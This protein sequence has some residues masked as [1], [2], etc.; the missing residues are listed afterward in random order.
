MTLDLVRSAKNFLRPLKNRL[1]RSR[2]LATALRR[3]LDPVWYRGKYLTHDYS[4]EPLEHYLSQGIRLGYSPNRW[5]DERFYLA[6][7]PDVAKVCNEG[8]ILCGFQHYLENGRREK[9]LT[10]HELQKC[11]EARMPGVTRPLLLDKVDDLA[12]R[13]RPI[14]AVK[15]ARASSTVWVL[16]PTLNPDITFG[17]Y[18][19]AIELIKTLVGRGYPVAIICCSEQ[20]NIE[21]FQHCMG[22]NSFGSTV[23]NVNLLNRFDLSG[24]V[25]VGINDRFIAYSCWE[26]H[27]AHGLA[28]L[29]NEP[30]FAL[31]AQEY[32]P[33]F[34]EHG[35]EHA[36]LNAAYDLPHLPIFNSD[37]LR[38]FFEQAKLGIFGKQQSKGCSEYIVI[39]HTHARVKAPTREGLARNGRSRRLVMYTRPEPHA[40][41]NLFPL[42][43]LGLSRAIERGVLVGSWEML[44]IGALS[45]GHRVQLPRGYELFL[46]PKMPIE[47]YALFIAG[48]DL[49]I[50]LMYA[51]HPGLVS[52]ELAEAGAR[53]VTNTFSIRSSE[54]LRGISENLVPCDPTIEGIAEGIER[55]VSGLDDTESRLRGANI[56]GPRS[57]DE[58]FDD[59]FFAKL[60]GFFHNRTR[61]GTADVVTANGERR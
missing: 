20:S 35:S 26:A 12:R 6:F 37:S 34:H 57:W 39:E 15:V 7:Y 38:Y 49:G 9:R 46:K 55:A 24:P 8:K 14:P 50:S 33:A 51:W 3:E 53:V 60:S 36:I 29:T 52:F 23:E 61:N 11:L 5:F 27:L 13:L 1:A 4:K 28:S 30:R 16:L 32:E 17:G 58:V 54:Y 31:L 22:A 56:P 47:E 41:R 25:E 59:K 10:R 18:R 2:C 40:A 21:Y 43:I 42:G 48:T 45:A 19:C 44:G